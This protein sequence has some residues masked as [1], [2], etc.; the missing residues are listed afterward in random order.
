MDVYEILAE[1]LFLTLLGNV[2]E[3]IL[4]I[5]PHQLLDTED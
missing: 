2:I 5:I 3:L 1:G 4:A